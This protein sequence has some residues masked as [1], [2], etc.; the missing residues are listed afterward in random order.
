MHNI[1][2]LLFTYHIKRSNLIQRQSTQQ[3]VVEGSSRPTGLC[4]VRNTMA[5]SFE[6]ESFVVQSTAK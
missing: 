6:L 4:L 5:Q 2:V 1:L 3:L